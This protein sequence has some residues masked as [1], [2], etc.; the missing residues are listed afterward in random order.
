MTRYE[1][2]EAIYKV[3][4]SGILSDELECELTDVCN[5][6]CEVGFDDCTGDCLRYCKKDECK[7]VND[8]N[9]W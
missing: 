7:H 1:A 6:L 3:I 4:N 9:S 5:C 2:K 8:C